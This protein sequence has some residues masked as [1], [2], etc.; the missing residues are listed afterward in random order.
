MAIQVV[1]TKDDKERVIGAYASG[2]NIFDIITSGVMESEL[3]RAQ[4]IYRAMLG[5]E[6]FLQ[7]CY[8]ACGKGES[9]EPILEKHDRRRKREIVRGV[10]FLKA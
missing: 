4:D 2:Q 10:L 9:Q 6:K 3:M 7:D 5:D 8:E 1:L